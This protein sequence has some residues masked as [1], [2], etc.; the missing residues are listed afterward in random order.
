MIL[1]VAA[2][3]ALGSPDGGAVPKATSPERAAIQSAF[4]AY[5][6]ALLEKNGGRCAALVDSATITYYQRMRDLAVT[7]RAAEIRK[8]GL[9]DK[10][11]IVRVRHQVPLAELKGMDGRGMFAYAVSQ[12]WIGDKVAKAQIGAIDV[13]GDLASGAF[14]VDGQPT[15]TRIGLRFERGAWRIDVL[16]LFPAAT[17]LFR[18]RQKE[19]GM[20]EDYFVLAAVGALV[21]KPVPPTIWDPPK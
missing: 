21:G 6:A 7:G 12:G 16:S 10:V 18:Q 11:M 9:L 4:K 1:L 20:S 2:A 19:S 14:M 3:L 8:L 17:F 5:Q 13:N 15:P